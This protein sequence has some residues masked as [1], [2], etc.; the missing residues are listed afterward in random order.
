[1]IFF[2]SFFSK[3]RL[4]YIRNLHRTLHNRDKVILNQSDL[5]ENDKAEDEIL[6]CAIP[7]SLQLY[8]YAQKR[9]GHPNYKVYDHELSLDELK[10][11]ESTF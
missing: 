2:L 5:P 11:E 9:E 10:R 6:D 1:L 4:G 3:G 7:G 8:P